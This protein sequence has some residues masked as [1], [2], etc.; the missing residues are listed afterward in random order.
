[1]QTTR[2]AF[3]AA[4]FGLALSAPLVL[5]MPAPTSAQSLAPPA[6]NT[7]TLSTFG[8]GVQIYQSQL[9]GSAYQWAFVA[10][11]ATLFTDSSELTPVATHFAGPTWKFTADGSAVVGMSLASRPSPNPGSIPELLL[12]AKSHDGAGVFSGITYIQRLNTVGGIA[13]FAAPTGAGQEADVPYTATYNFYSAAVP[14]ASTAGGF[15]VL[16]ALG[17]GGL[18]ARRRRAAR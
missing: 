4:F 2:I 17:L 12:A 14:E 16:L 8:D 7:L 5:G 15:G 13:P 6:G 18:A 10:P 9:V 11:R 1:M 3:R